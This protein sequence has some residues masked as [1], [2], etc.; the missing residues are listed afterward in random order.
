MEVTE[1]FVGLFKTIIISVF[2]VFSVASVIQEKPPTS[3]RV[4]G[5]SLWWILP[6]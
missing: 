5:M 2:S 4:K 1:V 6:S 3:E